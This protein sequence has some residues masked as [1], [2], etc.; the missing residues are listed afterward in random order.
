[1]AKTR[2]VINAKD[3]NTNELVYFKGHAKATYMSDGSTVEDGISKK[4]DIISDLDTIRANASLGANALQSVPDE[5][6]T[7]TELNQKGYLT[8]HQDISHK[9]DKLVSGTNI[10]TINGESIL[11]PGDIEFE[12]EANV[13]AVD[14]NDIV[15]D[16]EVTDAIYLSSVVETTDNDIVLQPNKY[17]KKTNESPEINI[18]LK[19]NNI[20][21]PYEYC[22]EFDTMAD[23]TVVN[24]PSNIRW[25]NCETPVFENN[26]T[27]KVSIIRNMGIYY[28][29]N[30]Q[31]ETPDGPTD[32]TPD[33][34]Y[35]NEYITIQSLEDNNEVSFTAD[36]MYSTDNSSWNTLNSGESI[37]INNGDK[38]RFKGTCS[39]TI[40][41]I[42]KFS[43]TQNYKVYG[44]IM[45]LLYGDDFIGKTDLTVHRYNYVFT[46]L[47]A[48]STTLIDTSELIL[49]A[50]TLTECCYK[51]MFYN[52][53]NMVTAPKLPATKL[54]NDCYQAMFKDCTSL[55]TAPE[56]PAMTI[57]QRCYQIM[58]DGCTSLTHVPEL[59]ATTLANGCYS[60]MFQDCTSLTTAPDL[61]AAKLNDYSY[62]NMFTG[63]SNLNYIKML[64]TDISADH[65]MYAFVSGAASSGTFIKHPDIEI[66]RGQDGIPYGWTIVNAEL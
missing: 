23:G 62:N 59:P 14:P 49:P 52:C 50:T 63:C 39:P 43:T 56:L 54:A 15:D 2:K 55:T 65:C 17:Y 1:M 6:I 44:N 34:A 4:Q 21:Y 33:N 7:E 3:L 64:A 12:I 19:N 47:F 13:K 57:A 53:T 5:Y 20:K 29:F 9:Q 24:F 46:T 66:P 37:L 60:G 11:G 22:L 38:V 30:K 35:I 26:Y 10:K 40:D 31:E 32:P 61:L 18:T 16:C 25:F 42:G 51:Y 45:S 58:F 36:I 48:N 27:Y 41:G 8:E 28:K